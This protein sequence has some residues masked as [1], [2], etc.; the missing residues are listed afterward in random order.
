MT[1]LRRLVS[2]LRAWVCRQSATTRAATHQ[3]HSAPGRYFVHHAH[4]G[5]APPDTR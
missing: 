3:T 5:S 2:R 1:A 4:G